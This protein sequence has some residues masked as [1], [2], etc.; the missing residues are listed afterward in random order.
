MRERTGFPPFAAYVAT[1]SD[2]MEAASTLNQF[3]KERLRRLF[4]PYKSSATKN[5]APSGEMKVG[6]H[7]TRE[8]PVKVLG[9]ISTTASQPLFLRR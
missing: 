4:L 3:G 9:A 6:P 8:H 1:S 5:T 2:K 7:S